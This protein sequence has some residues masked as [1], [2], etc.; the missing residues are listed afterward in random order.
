MAR[1]PREDGQTIVEY[2]MVLGLLTLVLFS[3]VTLTGLDEG[4]NNLVEA[5]ELAFS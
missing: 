1:L 4:F 2:A 5:I 3:F